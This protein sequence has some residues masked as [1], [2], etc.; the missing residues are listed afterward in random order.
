HGEGSSSGNGHEISCRD[1][2]CLSCDSKYARFEQL[3]TRNLLLISYWTRRYLLDSSSLALWPFKS[4]LSLPHG[5]YPNIPIFSLH[6]FM[7]AF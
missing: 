2:S 1:C 6:H 7:P 3:S 4:S 5:I